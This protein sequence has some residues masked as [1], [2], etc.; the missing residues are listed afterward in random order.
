ML[1][2]L[3]LSPPI[4]PHGIPPPSRL[5][6]HVPAADLSFSPCQSPEYKASWVSFLRKN[7][8]KEDAD[9]LLATAAQGQQQQ[10]QWSRR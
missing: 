9:R 2:F 6:P 7:L 3:P 4:A 1:S 5:M 8:C 10:Q